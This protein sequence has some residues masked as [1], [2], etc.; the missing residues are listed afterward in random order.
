MVF[1]FRSTGMDEKLQRD[2]GFDVMASVLQCYR[3]QR[4]VLGYAGALAATTNS[5][6]FAPCAVFVLVAR[7]GRA[8]SQLGDCVAALSPR[9]GVV[10]AMSAATEYSI[11]TF[12]HFCMVK[13]LN[14]TSFRTR[15]AYF[16]LFSLVASMFNLKT[17]RMWRLRR[18]MS[19]NRTLT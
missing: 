5:S 16:F 1:P 4:G 10:T 6:T 11:M 14:R 2:C 7:C 9:G 12:Q 3:A 18:E 15:L 13:S 17:A 19:T 8:G